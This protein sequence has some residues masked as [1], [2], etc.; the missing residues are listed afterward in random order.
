M[1]DLRAIVRARLA[2]LDWTHAELA[3]RM[4]AAAGGDPDSRERTVHRYLTL[5][6]PIYSDALETMLAALDLVPL[7]STPA[8]P[9]NPST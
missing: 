1:L 7:A 5:A 4:A 6:R 3:R 9:T 8:T 2:A